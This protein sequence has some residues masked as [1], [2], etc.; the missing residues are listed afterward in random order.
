MLKGPVHRPTP[1]DCGRVCGDGHLQTWQSFGH[2][3]QESQG[4]QWGASSKSRGWPQPLWMAWRRYCRGLES[5]RGAPVGQPLASAWGSG[6][7]A[8]QELLQH[9]QPGSSSRRNVM[10][11]QT[12]TSVASV[13]GSDT[14]NRNVTCQ[15]HSYM[16]RPNSLSFNQEQSHSS[17]LPK[18]CRHLR[19][20]SVLNDK[21]CITCLKNPKKATPKALTLSMCACQP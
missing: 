11:V 4:R 9:P 2:Q 6:R 16:L 5:G 12:A 15:G 17:L 8:L 13:V 14:A 20:A 3:G 10:T 1:G 7:C 21:S 19:A 18:G